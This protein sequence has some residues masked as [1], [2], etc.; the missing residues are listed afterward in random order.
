[1]KKR[2]K[3]I[4]PYIITVIVTAGIIYLTPLKWVTIVEPTIKDVDPKVFYTEYIKN[5]DHYIFID[6]RSESAY[7][8]GHAKGSVNMPLHT[9]YDAKYVL[10]KHDKEIVLICS[11]GRASG[12]GYSYLQ[13]YGFFNIARIKGGIEQWRVEGLPVETSVASTDIKSSL[14]LAPQL[15]PC[16]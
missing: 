12:V 10:P 9:L 14:S 15:I 2:I 16:V 13:H 8:A 6:V 5:P 11:G 7:A 3:K 1:M 4:A